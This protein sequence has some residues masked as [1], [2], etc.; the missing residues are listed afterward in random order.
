[1]VANIKL[2]TLAK[3]TSYIHNNINSTKPDGVA[4]YLAV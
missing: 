2:A 3:L 4:S 1:M